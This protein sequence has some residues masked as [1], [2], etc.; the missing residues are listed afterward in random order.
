[1]KIDIKERID[2]L[3]EQEVKGALASLITRISLAEPCRLSYSDYCPFYDKCNASG[4]RECADLWL[5]E[6]LK[7]AWK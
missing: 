1:M 4:T 3:S 7:E 6:A 5:D 2:R